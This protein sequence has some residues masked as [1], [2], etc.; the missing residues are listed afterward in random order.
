MLARAGRLL[1]R[2]SATGLRVLRASPDYRSGRALAVGVV[3]AMGRG[4]PLAALGGLLRL[5]ALRPRD[6]APLVSAAAILTSRGMPNEALSLLEA[7]AR[8]RGRTRGGWGSGV[9]RSRSTT[10]ARR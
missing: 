4:I 1:K 7:A 3:A 9:A 10:A 6:P 8:M 5:H 2:S